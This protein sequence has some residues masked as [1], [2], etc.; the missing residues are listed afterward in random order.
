M[1]SPWPS[2]NRLRPLSSSRPQSA[3]TRPQR[4][5]P[6]PGR[7]GGFAVILAVGLVLTGCASHAHLGAS[8]P[9][10][11]LTTAQGRLVTL[12]S[13]RGQVLVLN[14]WA[15]WCQPCIQETP[16]L[17]A[18]ATQ[19]HGRP[20]QI[21]GVAIY[22]NADRYRQ[23]LSAFNVHYPTARD[24][25]ADLAHRYGTRKIP[26]SYILDSRGV[27]VRKIVGAVNWDSP[28]MVQYLEDLAAGR[29]AGS[30]AAG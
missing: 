27:V 28:G 16:S 13:Y 10:F 8:A 15:S 2:G 5:G 17:N 26:E 18:L 1:P 23:Y 9:A 12:R 21:L 7:L 22:T 20:I 29:I 6:Q 24:F 11:S 25:S 14:F 30:P 19:L 3:I 4:R